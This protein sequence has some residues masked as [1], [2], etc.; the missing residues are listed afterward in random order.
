MPTLAESKHPHLFILII[1]LL[2]LAG[3]AIPGNSP[4][5]GLSA[6]EYRQQAYHS[7]HEKR[8]AGGAKLLQ[9][10]IDREPRSEDYLLLGDLREVLEQYRAARSAYK[11][12]LATKPGAKLH[13]ALVFHWATLEALEFNNP[14]E[15]AELASGLNENSAEAL[16]LQAIQALQKN[17]FDTALRLTDQVSSRPADQ[18]IKGWA[19]YHAARA[20]IAVGNESKALEAL[21]FAIN[22]AR[23]HGLVSRITRLWED[24]KQHPSAE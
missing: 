13:Q 24:L 23:G 12:G 18:E 10:A 4:H 21:F 5:D 7:I 14:T 6:E 17:H 16:T 1:G 20:W 11:K 8:Y 9:K 22:N 15:A 19:H 2:L 3:C